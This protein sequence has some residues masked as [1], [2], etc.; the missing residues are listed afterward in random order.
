MTDKV[1]LTSNISE[2]SFSLNWNLALLQV[3]INRELTTQ[4]SLLFCVQCLSTIL[5]HPC[6]FTSHGLTCPFLHILALC[7]FPHY[8]THTGCGI[9]FVPFKYLNPGPIL[10][11]LCISGNYWSYQE[12]HSRNLVLMW[13][14]ECNPI[15]AESAKPCLWEDTWSRHECLPWHLSCSLAVAIVYNYIFLL[16]I[17][18]NNLIATI[19][20][21]KARLYCLN[22]SYF[23]FHCHC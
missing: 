10:S 22:I 8:L 13:M 1:L 2:N 5:E 14:L 3:S 4:F 6:A 11:N 20:I 17:A 7:Y 18:M 16:V 23:P 21:H 19:K 9:H 12:T 15:A